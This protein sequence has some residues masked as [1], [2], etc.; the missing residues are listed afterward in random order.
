MHPLFF[1]PLVQ[2]TL[3]RYPSPLT[4]PQQSHVLKL[5]VPS[6]VAALRLLLTLLVAL[7]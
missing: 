4:V 1:A 5:L 2:Q 7:E 6:A 3:A